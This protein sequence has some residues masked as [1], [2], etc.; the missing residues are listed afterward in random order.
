MDYLLTVS[1]AEWDGASWPRWMPLEER[2]VRDGTARAEEG[3][4][5]AAGLKFGDLLSVHLFACR[6]CDGWPVRVVRG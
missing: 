6:R 3:Y 5:R 2:G 1:S 4:C